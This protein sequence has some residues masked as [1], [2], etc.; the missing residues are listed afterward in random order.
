[1]LSQSGCTKRLIYVAHDLVHFVH[2]G[3]ITVQQTI[4]IFHD[5]EFSGTDCLDI[6]LISLRNQM[7][8]IMMEKSQQDFTDFYG[9]GQFFWGNTHH[10]S[11]E[12]GS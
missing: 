5:Q 10:N 3:D 7:Q 11:R 9:G 6:T 8:L 12:I 1:M 2:Q 4:R